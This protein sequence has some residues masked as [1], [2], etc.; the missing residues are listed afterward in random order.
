WDIF[1]GTI[2]SQGYKVLDPHISAIYGDSITIERAEEI[3][4]RLETKGFASTNVVFGIGSYTY[5]YN[6]RDTFGFAMKATYAVVNGEERFLLK[7]PKT[8]DGT[9]KSLTGKVAVVKIGE[10][11]Y[12]NDGLSK[13]SY[14]ANF[15][16][17]DLLEDVF[18]DGELVRE[19]TL[20][21]IREI[22]K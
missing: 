11:L 1:G 2:T 7:D 19:Q 6:T 9:K 10:E 18:V 20:A 4:K 21:E 8:D 3:C 5:Q 16:R 14:D 13:H 12:A 22:L 17:I 15:A